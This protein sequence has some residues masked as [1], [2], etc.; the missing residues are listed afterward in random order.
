MNTDTPEKKT[1]KGKLTLI[2]LATFLA[3]PYLVVF[4]YQSYPE[5][6]LKTGMSNKGELFSPVHSIEQ[7]AKAE[8]D[9]LKGKW[10]IIYVS[11]KS[12][13]QECFNQ[14]YTMRQVR[15]ASAKRRF[16]MQRLNLVTVDKIDSAYT[17]LLAEF[18]DEKQITLNFDNKILQQFDYLSIDEQTGRIYL[19]DPY[20]N[21]VLRYPA[22]TNP[23][24]LL[25][26]INKLIAE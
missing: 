13:D 15:L 9:A 1:S 14:N 16:K 25:H 20:L 26:D 10:T 24:D 3:L 23:K 22:Q 2:L 21:I 19:M 17:E 11:G 8:F 4:I 12:C 6:S 18:P 7:E 5:L